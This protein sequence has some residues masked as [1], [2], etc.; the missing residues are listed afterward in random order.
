[1]GIIIGHVNIKGGAGKSTSTILHANFLAYQYNLKVAIIDA[2]DEQTT[3]ADQR[4]DDLR[5]INKCREDGI[6]IKIQ[7]KDMY[8]IITCP[9][10][11]LYAAMDDEFREKYDII[12]IDLPGHVKDEIIECYQMLD[13]IFIPVFHGNKEI[14]STI[15]FLKRYNEFVLQVRQQNGLDTL[16]YSFITKAKRNV[17]EYT[18]FKFNNS[19][20]WNFINN[21]NL[22]ERL[23]YYD[24]QKEKFWLP[25][26][27]LENDLEDSFIAFERNITTIG[28]ILN[29][30]NK[31]YRKFC[32]EAFDK[33][34][35]PFEI[36]E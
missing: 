9:S 34:H 13:V 6:D 4:I 17:R 26:E 22:T 14:R 2:D 5:Y 24:S 33:L 32:E 15:K 1:M 30:K 21:L 35:V 20:H 3:I 29:Y 10:T 8:D 19:H 16:I 27:F 7:E 31:D 28:S 12:F 25:V 23:K 18:K 11:E 36:V